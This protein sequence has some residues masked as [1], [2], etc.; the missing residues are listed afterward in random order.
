MAHRLIVASFALALITPHPPAQRTLVVDSQGRPGSHYRD[1][2]AAVGAAADG[3]LLVVRD[4]T[5]TALSTGKA[6]A[7]L[8]QDAPLIGRGGALTVTALPAGRTF[9]MEGFDLTVPVK[10]V[11]CDGRVH[12]DRIFS[13]VLN[14]GAALELDRAANVTVTTS[15][16]LGRPAI[17]C[18]QSTL[19]VTGSILHGQ[20]AS[21]V[22]TACYS[23]APALRA[24][25]GN[26]TVAGSVAKGGAG[27]RTISCN[28]PPSPA[29]ELVSGAL[30]IAGDT[31]SIW[32]A[33]LG[34]AASPSAPAVFTR[35][36]T[37]T[38]DPLVKLVPQGAAAP[39]TGSAQV[40]VRK[41]SSIVGA[42]GAPPGGVALVGVHSPAG[43]LV[44]LFAGAAADRL[45][46]PPLG[47]LWLAPSRA[48][49]AAV[50]QQGAAERVLFTIPIPASAPRGLPVGFQAVTG[51]G[52]VVLSTP[53][54]MVLD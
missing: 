31:A 51:Q 28:L 36:G 30:T 25:G 16:L 33:G 21:E 9:V 35:G 46:V 48:F 17:T 26:V 49:L 22:F 7:L 8:G 13:A 6:L 15:T 37:L 18:R 27:L 4:G 53:V 45:P 24:D 29:A 42:L 38:I 54:V 34:T 12:L 11:A 19:A 14:S 44:F 23:G 40:T 5:Y 52:D 20:D 10:V 3:D 1:L 32:E 47:D 50:A 41:I 39:I 43:D 2:P